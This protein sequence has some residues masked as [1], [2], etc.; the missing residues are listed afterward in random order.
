MI[1]GAGSITS[2]NAY[3]VVAVSMVAEWITDLE[4]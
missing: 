3:I 2:D 1:S 4:W